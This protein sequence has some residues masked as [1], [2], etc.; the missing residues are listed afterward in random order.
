VAVDV[1]ALTTT[2]FTDEPWFMN[3]LRANTHGAGSTEN[4]RKKDTQVIYNVVGLRGR[5]GGEGEGDGGCGTFGSNHG[6][7][8]S[9]SKQ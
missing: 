8:R 2:G 1:D 9:A 4:R 6:W 7:H 5:E 3:R